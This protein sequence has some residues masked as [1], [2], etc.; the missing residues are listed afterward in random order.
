MK[1]TKSALFEGLTDE[2]YS[3]VSEKLKFT[4]KS[5]SRDEEV[6]VFGK[7]DGK[8]LYLA[9]GVCETIRTD[10]DG[11]QALIER[12]SQ[13]A[14]F[15]FASATGFSGRDYVAV[16]AKTKCVVGIC[17][18]AEIDFSSMPYV[19]LKNFFLSQEKRLTLQIKR[20]GVLLG[21]TIRDKLMFYFRNCAEEAGSNTFE[22][23]T[24]LTGLSDYIFA[25]R[26]AMM[27]ELKKLREEGVLKINRRTVTLLK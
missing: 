21:R 23:N 16:I 2:E 20:T 8:L 25:D 3:V 19:F 13:G 17:E 10:E 12:Y 26:S 7:D 5:F 14:V 11:T 15:G 24:T 6:F 1:T 22:M 9:E 18:I 27:R 4:Y